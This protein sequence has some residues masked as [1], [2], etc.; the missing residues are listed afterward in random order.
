M[1]HFLPNHA[2]SYGMLAPL[3]QLKAFFSFP[4][5][6]QPIQRSQWFDQVHKEDYEQS[7]K[8]TQFSFQVLYCW[9]IHW[10]DSV[11]RKISH[12]HHRLSQLKAKVL[13]HTSRPRSARKPSCVRNRGGWVSTPGPGSFTAH[14]YL[15]NVFNVISY[16]LVEFSSPCL[17]KQLFTEILQR[18]F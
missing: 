2:C 16:L 1:L 9:L 10:C 14:L 5:S 6:Y 4:N 7:W 13:M 17:M 12:I 11:F 3:R 15:A 8:W 18:P